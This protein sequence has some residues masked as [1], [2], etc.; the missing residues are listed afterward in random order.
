MLHRLSLLGRNI[1]AVDGSIVHVLSQIAKLAW[2]KIGDGSPTCGYRLHTQ[3]EILKG[4]PHRI[5][6]ARANPKGPA[7]ERAVFERTLEPDR[8][9][10]MDR[11]YE[12]CSLWD[13]IVAKQSSYLCRV[14]DKIQ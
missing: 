14:R 4:V 5:D 8:L 6:A 7:G 9:Y 2:I 12:K 11:G 3:F 10:V 1:T 13:A